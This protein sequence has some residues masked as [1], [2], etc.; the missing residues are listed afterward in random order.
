MGKVFGCG[1]YFLVAARADP[2][3]VIRRRCPQGTKQTVSPLKL[4]ATGISLKYQSSTSHLSKRLGRSDVFQKLAKLFLLAIVAVIVAPVLYFTYINYMPH[5][6]LNETTRALYRYREV[7]RRDGD[8][9]LI[10]S[11]FS[12]GENKSN[13][14]RKLISAGLDAWNTTYRELPP[15]AASMQTFRFLAGAR[16]IVCGNELFLDLTYDAGDRLTSATIHQGGACL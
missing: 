13:I 2:K 7:T 4:Y 10:P 11:F 6:L 9:D 16:G 3:S 1:D 12:G 15:G 14:E 5:Q 8:V